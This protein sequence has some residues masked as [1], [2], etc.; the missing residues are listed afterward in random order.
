M[1]LGLLREVSFPWRKRQDQLQIPLQ[2]SAHDLEGLSEV[3]FFL[4]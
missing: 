3:H 2:Y 4:R 1:Q